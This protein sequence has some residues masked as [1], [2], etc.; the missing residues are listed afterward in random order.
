MKLIIK[1]QTEEKKDCFKF[2]LITL[3]VVITLILEIQ[4]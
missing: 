3:N 2:N 4:F 1:N